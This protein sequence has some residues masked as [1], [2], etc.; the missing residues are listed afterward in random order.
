MAQKGAALVS[1]AMSEVKVLRVPLAR[2]AEETLGKTSS[3]WS[4]HIKDGYR[5]FVIDMGEVMS[6]DSSGIG[7]LM[8]FYK[9]VREAG[10]KIHLARLNPR[11]DTLLS[12]V[13]A[14]DMFGIFPSVD[15]AKAAFESQ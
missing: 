10:G 1:Q 8:D 3:E 9:R 5:R 13:K 6:M 2:M 7:C 12:L 11:V 4:G 15:A 14:R